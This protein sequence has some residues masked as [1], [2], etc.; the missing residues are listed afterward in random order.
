MKDNSIY[1]YL[2]GSFIIILGFLLLLYCM[3]SILALSLDSAEDFFSFLFLGILVIIIGLI[4]IVF[5]KKVMA[6]SLKMKIYIKI[7][8]VIIAVIILLIG[9]GLNTVLWGSG[10]SPWSPYFQ[11]ETG[12]NILMYQD[13]INNTLNV[14]SV[15]PTNIIWE[16]IEL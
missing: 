10:P 8:L 7:P 4:L 3:L 15:D 9:A 11:T 6:R 5:A 1:A 2:Y 16:D 13:D 12:P 14:I